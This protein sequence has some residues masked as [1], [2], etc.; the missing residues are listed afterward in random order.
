MTNLYEF[1]PLEASVTPS[2]LM[3]EALIF[4]GV[5]IDKELAGYRTLNVSGRENFTRTLNTASSSAD[6]EL[7]ISSKI[8]TNDITIKYELNATNIDDFNKRYTKLKLLLQGEEV[9]FNFADE[10]EFYRIGTVIELSN[11]DVGS[12]NTTGTIKIKMSD[13]YR[14]GQQKTISGTNVVTLNDPQLMYPQNVEKIIL[15]VNNDTDNIFININNSYKLSLINGSFQSNRN[16]VVD[17]E[18]KQI[19]MNGVSQLNKIDIQNTNIFEA[20]I[21][22]MDVLTCSQAKSMS[23]IYRVKIL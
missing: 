8:D 4:G 20:K 13:P 3:P 14:K 11:D 17:I 18:N 15:I 10:N 16:I 6:G 5:N 22:N 12:I 2:V 21:K 19:T 23:V 1:Q 7:F 9:K